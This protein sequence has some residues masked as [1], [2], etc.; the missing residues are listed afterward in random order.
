MRKQRYGI[1]FEISRA[2]ARLILPRFRFDDIY[3]SEE[4]TVYV[5]HHQ[6]MVGPISI[7][8][9]LKYY[10]RTWIL[11]VFASQEECYEHYMNYTFTKRYGWPPFFAKMVAW[12]VSYIVPWLVKSA[13]GIPVYRG[14]RKIIDTFKISVDALIKGE[15]ILIFPDIDY[16]DDSTET[17]D[18]YEGFLNLEK[19]YYRKTKEHLTFVPIY[20]DKNKRK[21]RSGTAIQF[22]GDK[23]FIEERK[24]IAQKIQSELNRLANI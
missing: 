8:A 21:V 22:K 20:S 19:Y 12:P 14:S 2:I 6:N 23:A 18:I 5:S 10:L 24:E 17:S 7:L 16:S 3:I 15:D 9:W 1:F 4:P 13:R 11:S